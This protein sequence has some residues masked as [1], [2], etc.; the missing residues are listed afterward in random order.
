[1]V[2]ELWIDLANGIDVEKTWI[3]E[4][5]EDAMINV[6]EIGGFFLVIVLLGEGEVG[7]GIVCSRCG[8]V[9]LGGGTKD[10]VLR[11]YNVGVSI[12]VI[13]IGVRARVRERERERKRKKTDR[14]S[15]R[16]TQM[17]FQRLGILPLFST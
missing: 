4:G 3:V 11:G 14:V 7:V 12:L 5:L 10:V 13:P 2:D 8:D 6:F 9:E 17:Y 16:S 1:M 15:I